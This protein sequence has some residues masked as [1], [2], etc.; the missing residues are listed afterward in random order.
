[1]IYGFVMI[2]SPHLI[3]GASHAVEEVISEE[4][5]TEEDDIDGGMLQ[6]PSIL[7]FGTV[8]KSSSLSVVFQLSLSS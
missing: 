4:I 1:M 7:F 5:Q 2:N 8:P 3:F 6:C